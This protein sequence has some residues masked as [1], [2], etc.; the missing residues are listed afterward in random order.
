MINNCTDRNVRNIIASGD[1]F[2][3]EME[4]VMGI[5]LLEDIQFYLEDMLEL[6]FD[7]GGEIFDRI[8]SEYH[9]IKWVQ[10]GWLLLHNNAES[11]TV[12]FVD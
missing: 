11:A 1:D 8:I 5:L 4:A 7:F 6:P 3:Y 10:C 12:R 2:T 9:N